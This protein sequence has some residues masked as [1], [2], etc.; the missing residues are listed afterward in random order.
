[1]LSLGCHFFRCKT[2]GNIF[3]IITNF[4]ITVCA[5]GDIDI[6]QGAQGGKFG[7]LGEMG[8]CPAKKSLTLTPLASAALVTPTTCRIF[9]GDVTKIPILFAILTS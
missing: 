7:T 3:D 5:D 2:L 1:M 9:W 6:V 8:S 4:F